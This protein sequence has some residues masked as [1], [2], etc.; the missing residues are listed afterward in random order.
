MN[1]GKSSSEIAALINAEFGEGAITDTDHE[2]RQPWLRIDPDHLVSV[3]AWLHDQPGLYF[4]MLSC[5]S[6]VDLGPKQD[7]VEV[8]YHL[9]SIPYGHK[10][11]LRCT[12]SRQPLEGNDLP[13][14]P[15]I[16]S[17]WPTADWHEREAYDLVG[18]HFEGH[19][20]LRRILMPEDWEGHPLRKDYENPESYHGIKTAY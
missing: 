2:V 1:Q 11:V 6:G 13:V 8:V 14:I 20:D 10:L 18:I 15:S 7:Q 19:P 17:I 16:S 3:C 12:V 9:Y 4:D 5:L